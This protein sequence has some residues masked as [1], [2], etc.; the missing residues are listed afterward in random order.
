MNQYN[1]FYSAR[2]SNKIGLTAQKKILTIIIPFI[3][4]FNLNFDFPDK[5]KQK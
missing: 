4:L 1:K 3:R 5:T 2:K